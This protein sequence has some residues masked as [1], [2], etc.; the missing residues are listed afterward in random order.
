[1]SGNSNS[2][3]LVGSR[4]IG[5]ANNNKL[6]PIAP[7]FMLSISYGRPCS[8]HQQLQWE[9]K[10]VAPSGR[11]ASG[12]S[13]GKLRTPWRCS[14]LSEREGATA[15]NLAG[16]MPGQRRSSM[17][18][19]NSGGAFSPARFAAARLVT[20]EPTRSSFAGWHLVVESPQ[21]W[22]PARRHLARCGWTFRH[23]AWL[24][25]RAR[26]THRQGAGVVAV[27]G[28]RAKPRGGFLAGI[29]APKFKPVTDAR[30]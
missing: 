27:P 6:L 7:Y 28:R 3:E 23:R 17:P 5:A 8:P 9:G 25:K 2:G 10:G 15:E 30:T 19:C 26:A 11:S 21:S 24:S 29:E 22:R 14:G 13:A 20:M 16:T 18:A 12:A 1:M 4:T